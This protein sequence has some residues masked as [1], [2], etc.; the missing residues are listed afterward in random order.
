MKA[1]PNRSAV[2]ITNHLRIDSSY[3]TPSGSTAQ[4]G[5]HRW[6]W[7]EAETGTMCGQSLWAAS[8]GDSV[9]TEGSGMVDVGDMAPDFTLK[10]ASGNEVTLSA[11]SG[12]KRALL[13]FYPEDGTSG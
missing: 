6:E 1:T 11:L 9:S 7:E 10:G 2:T 3:L 13:I 5:C 8:G 12:S 4:I